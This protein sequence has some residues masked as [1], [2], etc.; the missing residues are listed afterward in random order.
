[1][2]VDVAGISKPEVAIKSREVALTRVVNAPRD[3]VYQAFT[4]ANMLAKWFGPHGFQNNVTTDLRVGGKFRIEMIGPDG[5]KYPMFGNYREVV[6]NEKIVFTSDLS[7]HSD[8]WKAMIRQNLSGPATEDE[9]LNSIAEITFED[10]APN[11]T[12]V[13]VRSRFA[14]SA[15]LD[16]YVKTGMNEGWSQSF[17]RLDALVTDIDKRQIA[18]TRSL[19]APRELVWKVWTEPEH[20]AQ[21]WGPKGFTNTIEKMDVREGGEWLFYMNGP[22]GTDYRNEITYEEVVP[23]ERL[24]YS[25]GPSP[26]FNAT[27]TFLELNGKTQLTMRM[28]FPTIEERNMTV[29][30]YGALEGQKQTFNRLEQYI[31]APNA[32]KT[33]IFERL[34]DTE[35]FLSREFD[36]P[37][38]LLFK[39]YTDA[40][41]IPD[42]WGPRKES[43]VVDK[44]DLRAGGEWRFVSTSPNGIVHGFHGQ[45]I[46]VDPPK[47]LAMT[48]EYEGAPGH[49]VNVRAIFEE[50]GSKRSRVRSWNTFS[51]KEACDGMVNSGMQLG[52]SE[53]NDRLDE[54]LTAIS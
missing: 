18:T 24:S 44:C 40:K 17:E 1:M 26:K 47:E 10:A 7:D 6:P 54:V 19:N 46:K 45:Y 13:T 43:V 34:S 5:V 32:R 8:E 20:I 27:V 53:S 12:K 14:S 36:A 41:L 28:V 39:V 38:D 49:I 9:M 25:H 50:M 31:K 29:E 3:L 48:F 42:W 11:A 30:K 23:L 33:T 52:A 4:D 15:V 2:T 16:S 21:W 37:R 51:S 22:D 35:V